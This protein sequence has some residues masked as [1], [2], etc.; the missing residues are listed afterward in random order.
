L[1]WLVAAGFCFAGGLLAVFAALEDG[2]VSAI[3][4][5][6]AAQPLA[7]VLLSWLLLHDIERITW[8][9]VVGAALVVAGVIGIAIGA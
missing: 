9:M 8:R 7:I 1:S 4:P 3:G 5:I 6:I 2:A